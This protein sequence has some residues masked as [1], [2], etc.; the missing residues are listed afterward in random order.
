MSRSR[1]QVAA[2][3]APGLE[4]AVRRVFAPHLAPPGEGPGWRR[5][6]RRWRHTLQRLRPLGGMSLGNRVERFS[7]G[8]RLFEAL[9][10]ALAGAQERVL[11]TTY[12]LSPDNVGRRTIAALAD[13]AARG[14]RVTL[15]YDAVGSRHLPAAE[16]ETLVRLGGRVEAYNPAWTLR[17][18]LAN[19]AV[20]DHRKVVVIDG[21]VA[22][23]GGM[24]IDEGYAGTRH[25]SG[26]LRDTHLRIEGP[27]GAD[28]E[29]VFDTERAPGAPPPFELEPR[30]GP[31]VLL[32]VLSS[33]RWLRR[34]AIQRSLRYTISRA[35]RRVWLTNPYFLP[36]RRLRRAL[37][38]AARRG[39]DVRLLTVGPSDVPSVRAISQHVYGHFLRRG[40][41][42]YELQ[43]RVLHAK[44]AV[45]DGVYASVGSF[46]L[47]ILSDRYN[48]ELNVALLDLGLAAVLEEDFKRDLEGSRELTLAEWS[49]RGLWNRVWGWLGYQL[50]KLI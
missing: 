20:R 32:Q 31:G 38:S 21:R 26:M 41:R 3:P 1:R 24:N 16:L 50:S 8:D 17:S 47:D 35:E 23:C 30:D 44:T 12:I 9:W 18:R 6:A 42:I 43:S 4:H 5:L 33:N 27:A 13:A 36:P 28:F 34:R 2:A 39:V 19:R 48:H 7:D 45:I 37:T 25:G 15:R 10:S 14:V 11:A 22:F 40:V 46:N 29:A 49:E